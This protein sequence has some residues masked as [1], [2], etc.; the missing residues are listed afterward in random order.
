MDDRQPNFRRIG[1]LLD[2]RSQNHS[3][4][5]GKFYSERFFRD[6]SPAEGRNIPRRPLLSRRQGTRVRRRGC[7][8]FIENIFQDYEI[9]KGPVPSSAIYFNK[10]LAGQ[11]YDPDKARKLLNEAGFSGGN[12]LPEYPFISLPSPDFDFIVEDLQAVGF[13]IKKLDPFPGWRDRLNQDEPMLVRLMNIYAGLDV[14]GL[15]D[16]VPRDECFTDASFLREFAAWHKDGDSYRNKAVLNRLEEII[17]DITPVIFLY[18]IDGDFRFLQRNV[19][20]RQLG[21]VWENK[22]H[23]VW[24][25]DETR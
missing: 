9:A 19:R 6:V 5:G 21:G 12:G 16:N 4:A 17:T 7:E 13:K 11:Y 20:D 18:H 15:L 1:C 3:C 24:L 22:L 14:Y 2:G 10:D 8:I 25:D 23:Y